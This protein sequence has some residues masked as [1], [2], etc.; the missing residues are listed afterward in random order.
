MERNVSE[1]VYHVFAVSRFLKFTH[2]VRRPNLFLVN[3][4]DFVPRNTTM[5]LDDLLKNYDET[6]RP[7]FKQG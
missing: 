5:I 6:E 2:S 4:D 3:Y 7:D 1:T